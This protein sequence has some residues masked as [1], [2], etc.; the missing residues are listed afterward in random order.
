MEWYSYT[1][2]PT[3]SGNYITVYDGNVEFYDSGNN[4]I[5]ED[6]VD[7]ELTTGEIF[8]ITIDGTAYITAESQVHPQWGAVYFG[9][10]NIWDETDDGTGL[11]FCAYKNEWGLR[12][13]LRDGGDP[14]HT[15]KI[16]RQVNS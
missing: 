7:M 2:A 16:E 14:T 6:L 12:F 8:R 1:P 9:N 3:P 15:I 4:A 5:I 13:L 11:P 10:V